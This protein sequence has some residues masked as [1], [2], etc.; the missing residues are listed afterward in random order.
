MSYAYAM[1][2][3]GPTFGYAFAYVILRIYIDPSLTPV[4][5]EEDPHWLGAWW[6]GWIMI[7]TLMF[8]F[9]LVMGLFPR[10]IRKEIPIEA[11]ELDDEKYDQNPTNIEK[12]TMESKNNETLKGFLS[13]LSGSLLFL[14]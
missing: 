1:R 5:A 9:A 11:N 4:I 7:G 14:D 13:Y 6:L 12:M 10:R 3:F 2:M 8:L